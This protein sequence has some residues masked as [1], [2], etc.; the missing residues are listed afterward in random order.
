[1]LEKCD[2]GAVSICTSEYAHV[3]PAV[4]AAEAQK[5]ILLEKPIAACYA[6]GLKI[7]EAAEKNGVRL[8]VAQAL[9]FDGRYMNLRQTIESGKLGEVIS[10]YLKRSSYHQLA[11]RFSGKVS[12]LHYQGVH[13]FESMLTFAHPAKP[14]KAYSQAVSKKNAPFG[15]QDTVFNTITFDNGIV[16]SIQICWALPDNDALSYVAWCEVL[17]TKAVG[18]IDIKENGISIYDDTSVVYPDYM[19]WPVDSRGEVYGVTRDEIQ[20]FVN[21]TLKGE[22]YIVDTQ[23]AL[24]AV[25][26]IDACFESL[27]TGMPVAITW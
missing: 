12:F 26:V 10:M 19:A 4:A 3:E 6:D 27:R 7:K 21:A 24:N 15:A 9:K 18:Y 23:N 2:I 17:G 5:T 11:K 1:M 25:K 8:M 13:D 22:E 16:A 20:H 14:I